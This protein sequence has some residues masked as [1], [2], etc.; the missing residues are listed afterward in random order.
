MALSKENVQSVNACSEGLLNDN[1]NGTSQNQNTCTS[2]VDFKMELDTLS[3]STMPKTNHMNN[4]NGVGRELDEDDEEHTVISNDGEN[5]VVDC[6]PNKI[7]SMLNG[8][9]KQSNDDEI[10]YISND[11]KPTI[12]ELQHEHQQQ[13]HHQPQFQQQQQQPHQQQLP[14][15]QQS[16][17]VQIPQPL[18]QSYDMNEMFAEKVMVPKYKCKQCDN[19]Y[20]SL[21]RVRLHFLAKH[22]GDCAT[23]TEDEADINGN[24][25]YSVPKEQAQ[26]VG[27]KKKKGRKKKKS[28]N[29]YQWGSSED[30]TPRTPAV[31]K[32]KRPKIRERK[33]PCDW[34]NCLYSAK[35]AVSS[36]HV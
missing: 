5:H 30:E 8:L 16:H 21:D 6:D 34:P 35:T 14:H 10:N 25:T 36:F 18:E 7:L 32:E 29:E 17:L 31:G 4:D 11:V 24:I 19:H 20:D 23:K 13:G 22:S 2:M 26:T 15:P 33:H 28:K 3:Y 1:N 9:I 27:P 12:V